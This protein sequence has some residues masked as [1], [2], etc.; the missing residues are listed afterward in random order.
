MISKK[1]AVVPNKL[2]SF[3]QLQPDCW[4]VTMPLKE[5]RVSTLSDGGGV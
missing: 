5:R 3:R 2:V 1:T 4:W